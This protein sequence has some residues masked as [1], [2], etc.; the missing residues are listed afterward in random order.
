MSTEADHAQVLT[1]TV[2]VAGSLTVLAT[3]MIAVRP[4]VR[5]LVRLTDAMAWIHS[6]TFTSRS[7]WR[8]LMR[9]AHAKR[10]LWTTLV[11]TS[12]LQTDEPTPRSLAVS[13]SIGV[14]AR[15]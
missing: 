11:V 13:E 6:S 3:S 7:W 5:T 9:S 4:V 10:W 15:S 2:I 8:S 12:D 1:F 14:P